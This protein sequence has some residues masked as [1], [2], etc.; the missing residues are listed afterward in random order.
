MKEWVRWDSDR[1]LNAYTKRMT[2]R[3]WG[4]GI[5]MAAFARLYGVGVHVY[6]RSTRL[7]YPFKRISK[8]AAPPA[9][10]ARLSHPSSSSSAPPPATDQCHVA[11]LYCGRSHYDALVPR[12]EPVEL[13]S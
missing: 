13:P 11:V 4:G 3:G 7:G 2:K 5:E 6:E 12:A 9:K 10:R 1:T 8:F